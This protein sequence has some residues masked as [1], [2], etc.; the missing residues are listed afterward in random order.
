MRRPI[1]VV[2]EGLGHPE[3]P[4]ELDDGR[5]VFANTYA[6]RLDV[7]D[8]ATGRTATYA[9]VGGGPNACVLGSDELI[10]STQTPTV[11]AWLPADRRPPSIQRS[12]PDGKVEILATEADGVAFTGPN[13][14]AFGPDGR[15]YFTNSGDWDPV[16]RPHAGLICVLDRG[17][18]AHVLEDLGPVYPNGIVVEHDGSVV[19]VESYTLKV[20]RRRPD[21]TKT[22]IHT[23]PPGHI[24]DGLKIDRDNNLWIAAVAAGGVDIIA[25]DGTPIDF[26]ATGGTILNCAFGRGGALYCC[27]MGPFDTSGASMNGRLLRVEVGVEGMAPLRGAIA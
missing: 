21:G 17:G 11:G 4:C 7:Y 9:D 8:P 19:W 16:T 2:S 23:M 27:D 20:V 12:A 6:S 1:A 14:L 15:L 22:V 13:D 24:P 5:V 3:G 18:T 10:Y 26:L 25:H